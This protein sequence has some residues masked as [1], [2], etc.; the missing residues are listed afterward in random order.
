MP[1]GEQTLLRAFYAKE[2]E[3]RS[4]RI[5]AMNDLAEKQGFVCPAMFNLR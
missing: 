5:E 1:L 3:E 2:M 4:E